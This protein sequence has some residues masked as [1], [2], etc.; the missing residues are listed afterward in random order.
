MLLRAELS[1]SSLILLMLDDARHDGCRRC[2]HAAAIFATLFSM[3]MP[4]FTPPMPMPAATVICRP[5][6]LS[7]TIID[8]DDF[9]DY[10][11]F[12]AAHAIRYYCR[13]LIY[14]HTAPFTMPLI[15]I[16]T[17]AAAAAAT[18]LYLR[19]ATDFDAAATP[20][21]AAAAF[22]TLICCR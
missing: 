19:Y 1:F 16:A 18:P 9:R 2:R 17:P 22:F 14:E 8:A 11:T 21:H 13:L 20:R 15:F 12:D 5:L 3:L 6:P 4:P 10:A 7:A